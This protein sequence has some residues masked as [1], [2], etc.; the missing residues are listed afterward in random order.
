M[1]EE[2]PQIHVDSDWKAQAQQE[3]EKLAQQEQA[4]QGEGEGQ[5]QGQGQMPPATFETLMSTLA[6]QAMYALGMIPD[7]RT[8][9][10]SVSLELAQHHIDMLGVLEEKTQGNLTKEEADT[11]SQVVNELRQRFVQVSDAV[12]QQA[13]QQAQGQGQAGQGGGIAQ[14]GEGGQASGGGQIYTG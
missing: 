4:K 5:Q 12:K 13:Q 1:A 3:K 14:P 2:E 9:Q 6:T 11:L 7:P 8:G 10:A